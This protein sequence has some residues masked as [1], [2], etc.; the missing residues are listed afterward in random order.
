[1][2][3]PYKA[4]H[5]SETI[6]AIKVII[7]R[8]KLPVTETLLGDGDMFCSCRISLTHDG[9]TSIGT[10]GKGMDMEYALASGYA[11][12]MERL[13]NRVIVYPNPSSINKKYRFFSDEREYS[14]THED[15]M[16]IIRKF[17]PMAA[18]NKK[19]Q[20]NTLDGKEVPFYHYNSGE[21]R[22]VPYSLIRWVNGS[23]GMCAGNI[24]EEAVIQG[25]NEI[26]ERYCIQR[27]YLT[28][29]T[30]PDIPLSYFEGSEILK[31]L[32]RMKTDYGYDF[33][34]KDCSLGE[35]FPVLGLLVYNRDRSKYIF[36]LGADLSAVTALERCFTEIFQGYTGKSLRF[37]N[38]INQCERLDLFN[39]FK[40]SLMHGRGQM[41]PEFFMQDESY[42]FISHGDIPIGKNFKEDCSNICDWLVSKGYDIY[43]RDNSFLGFPTFHIVVP[44]LSEIN[45]AFCNLQRRIRHMDATENKF[46]PLYNLP[47]IT[48]DQAVETIG[49]L[50]LLQDDAIDLFP[51]NSA[52]TNH[53]NRHLIL[54]LLQLYAG[55]RADSMASLKNYTEYCRQ[56]GKTATPAFQHLLAALEEKES[57]DALTQ[58]ILNN[59][60]WALQNIGAPVCFD[61]ERCGISAYCRIGLLNEIEAKM[62][63]ALENYQFHQ[64]T[65]PKAD[66]SKSQCNFT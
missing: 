17:V 63:I 29:I 53:V 4:A 28:R 62:Q 46:N 9:D 12:F 60:L 39:E 43:I 32:E 5:P 6:A 19:L 22:Y 48:L 23:N 51:R 8:H 57:P 26:F 41:H 55:E 66:E 44:G 38:D 27:L 64:Y 59:P 42:P 34:I 21:C 54:A 45:A 2:T 13:Q 1:M 16:R 56:S 25:F 49:F 37:E 61:C 3:K 47:S 33:S 24:P 58:K 35:G 36:H 20:F 11:E 30:P 52:P 14:Y 10:N 65:F 40:R 50:R 31:R 15:G 18:S 7:E